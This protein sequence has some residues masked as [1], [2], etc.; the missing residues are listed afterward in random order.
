MGQSWDEAGCLWVS[1]GMRWGCLWVNPGVT[2]GVDG[3]LKDQSSEHCKSFLLL[4][5]KGI[6]SYQCSHNCKE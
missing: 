4:L 1:L 2:L 6:P 3:A 5:H